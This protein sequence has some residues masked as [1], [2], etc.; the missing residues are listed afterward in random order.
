LEPAAWHWADRDNAP[1]A[2]LIGYGALRES[3]LAEGI[4]ALG[5]D[6]HDA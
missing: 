5:K 3:T 1:A 2:L 4:E 6:L